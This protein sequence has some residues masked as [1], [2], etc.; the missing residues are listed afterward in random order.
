MASPDRSAATAEQIQAV[1]EYEAARAQHRRSGRLMAEAF[2]ACC[3]SGLEFVGH[4]P[5]HKWP[6]GQGEWRPR[7]GG[8][9]APV[10]AKS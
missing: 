4:Y 3:D 1:R 8:P 2:K 7:A 9:V 6:I 10:G 5:N